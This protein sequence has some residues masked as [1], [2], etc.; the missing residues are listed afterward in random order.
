M[1]PFI[2]PQPRQTEEY[3]ATVNGV[4][5][6]LCLN[7]EDILRYLLPRDAYQKGVPADF[8][9][10]D[11]LCALLTDSV[12]P[13][14]TLHQDR[15]PFQKRE[16]APFYPNARYEFGD[17]RVTLFRYPNHSVHIRED[18]ENR[19]TL[20]AGDRNV[21]IFLLR[22][23]I[24]DTVSQRIGLPALH[25]GGVAKASGG[26]VF[27]APG[28]GGKSTLALNLAARGWSLLHD[29]LIFADV[30]SQVP[31]V[32]GA[33]IAPSLR[34]AALPWVEAPEALLQGEAVYEN[35]YHECC[36]F[37]EKTAKT[38]PVPLKALL[39][40]TSEESQNAEVAYS[41]AD[42]AALLEQALPKDAREAL[43]A[44]PVYCLRRSAQMHRICAFLDTLVQP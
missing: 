39:F 1:I 36:Y 44:L 32:Q 40:L 25:A 21:L 26:V 12:S 16:E 8:A 38:G 30:R 41:P 2:R 6:R 10:V 5:L 14:Y 9:P 28:N 4:R 33:Q 43:S 3:A 37:P 42:P 13:E 23:A 35:P 24:K 17:T 7:T 22:E 19:T 29:D 18:K 15:D 11:T 27:L 20:L 31:T 34:K